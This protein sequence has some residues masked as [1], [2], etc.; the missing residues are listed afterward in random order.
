MNQNPLLIAILLS[1]LIAAV[2]QVNA[3][4]APKAPAAAPVQAPGSASAATTPAKVAA[5]ANAAPAQAAAPQ[6]QPAKLGLDT[7]AAKQESKADDKD[8]Q[9]AEKQARDKADRAEKDRLAQEKSAKQEQARTEK[10]SRE[11]QEREQKSQ[12]DKLAKADKKAKAEEKEN[13]FTS[14]PLLDYIKQ[15][16]MRASWGIIFKSE[17]SIPAWIQALDADSGPTSQIT[18]ADG[19]VYVVGAMNRAGDPYDRLVALFNI[20]KKKQWA[21]GINIPVSLGKEGLQHP[22]KYAT[23]RW[24]GNPDL[25]IRKVFTDYLDKDPSWKN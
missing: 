11:K 6:A 21:V 20:E 18:G 3:E 10:A 2:P 23:L 17:L 5:P 9:K 14:M 24:Y 7:P 22:K 19:T 13:E 15:A 1:G 12:A 25:T 16:S 8:A 4:E